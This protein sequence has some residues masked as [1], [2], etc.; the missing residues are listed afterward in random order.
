MRWACILLPELALDGVLR[1]CA[2]PDAPLVL[3]DGPSQ[4][5]VL[6]AVNPPA[7]A[8]GLRRGMGLSAAQALADGFA[9][10]EYSAEDEARS[11]ALL[12]AWAYRYSSQVSMQ[13]PRSLLLEIRGSL[14]LFGPWPRLEARLREELD[15]LGFRHRIAAAPYPEA[16]RALVRVHDGLAIEHAEPLR[17]ALG[18]LPVP[19][20]GFDAATCEAMQGMGL[21]CLRQVWALPRETLARRFPRSVLQQLDA[22]QG[23]RELPLHWYRPPDRFELRIELGHEVES[24][25]AL[26]F[27]LRRLTADLAAFLAGRDGG[28][29]RFVLQ[30]EHEGRAD[31]EVVVGMLAAERDPALLFELAR[32]RLE[33]ARVPAPVRGLALRA[34][35]LPAFVPAHR[36]LFEERPQQ[37]VP[38]ELLRERLRARLGEAA[39]HG[40]RSHADHRPEHASRSEPLSQRVASIELPETLGARPRWLLPNPLPLRGPAPELLA[41]P[42]RIESGWWDGGDVRRDY[43]IAR[44]AS[45]QRAWIYRPVGGDGFMLHGWF[46]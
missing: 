21:R 34:D 5:R 41:G 45:G 28:V 25:Q 6:H 32:S 30:L 14:R 19:R 42:E 10:F 40:L 11:H 15:A 12:A 24:S 9:S 31:T 16:A 22:L 1:R 26:L 43:Y 37:A 17:R 36:E 33:Q 3:I 29:Q 38:W 4:R 8:L 18:Q 46:A 13:F 23:E 39:L 27:P 44:L 20:A 35:E 2:D 7:R